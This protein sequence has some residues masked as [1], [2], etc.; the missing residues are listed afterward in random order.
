MNTTN[1]FVK[2]IVI[3]TGALMWVVLSVFT[4]RSGGAV[5]LLSS[6]CLR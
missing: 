1:L 3:G 2:L 5:M 4:P 6:S